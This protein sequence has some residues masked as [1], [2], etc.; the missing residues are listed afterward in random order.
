MKEGVTSE[1]LSQVFF[2]MKQTWWIFRK[3]TKQ[4]WS[5]KKRKKKKKHGGFRFPSFSNC[6]NVL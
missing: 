6:F 5:E 4:T 3:Q 1:T 2:L